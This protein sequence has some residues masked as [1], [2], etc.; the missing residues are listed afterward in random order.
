MHDPYTLERDDYHKQDTV[1]LMYLEDSVA[2]LHQN[3]LFI[4]CGLVDYYL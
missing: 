3:F 1:Q 4:I 2:W